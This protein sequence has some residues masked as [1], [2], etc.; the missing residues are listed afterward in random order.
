MKLI[1]VTQSD[2][3]LGEIG[4]PYNCPV[5]WAIK[6]KVQKGC[7][8]LVVVSQLAATIGGKR[9]DF[10]ERVKRRIRAFDAQRERLPGG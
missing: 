5:A 10:S 4:S 1:R 6:R 2:I 7:A 8:P 3:Y 9:I